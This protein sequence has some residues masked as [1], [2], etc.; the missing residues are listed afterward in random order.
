MGG[1]GMMPGPLIRD[2]P[3]RFA[4]EP[5]AQSE[6]IFVPC[7]NGI[8]NIPEELVDSL[9]ALSPR[10]IVYLRDDEDSMTIASV[11]LADGRRRQLNSRYRS[12]M[13]RT[14]TRLAIVDMKE[15]LRIMAVEWR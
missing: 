11:P 6:M 10:R 15:S 7:Q 8:F 3:L 12:P 13:F 4:E 14:A 9:A 1:S 5:M 2:I